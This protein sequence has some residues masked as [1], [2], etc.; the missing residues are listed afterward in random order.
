M[1]FYDSIKS[2]R[3]REDGH[4]V[5]GNNLTKVGFKKCMFSL[6]MECFGNEIISEKV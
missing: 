5:H 3:L 2:I 6:T 1:P 4:I